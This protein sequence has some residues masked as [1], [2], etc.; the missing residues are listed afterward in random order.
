MTEYMRLNKIKILFNRVETDGFSEGKIEIADGFK[1]PL[2]RTDQ[3][4]IYSHLVG[5]LFGK[6]ICDVGIKSGH[7]SARSNIRLPPVSRDLH[8]NVC[9][10]HI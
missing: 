1:D 3:P 9:R 8:L 7:C 4:R 2:T 6:W 10:Y 5:Y